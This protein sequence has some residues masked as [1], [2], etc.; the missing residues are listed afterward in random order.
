MCVPHMRKTLSIMTHKACTNTVESNMNVKIM[1]SVQL[2]PGGKEKK[3]SSV[4]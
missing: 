1:G 2:Y 3:Y 4:S